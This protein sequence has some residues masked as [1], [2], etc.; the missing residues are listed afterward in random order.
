LPRGRRKNTD[1]RVGPHLCIYL[2]TYGYVIKSP[3]F[4]KFG[5]IRVEASAGTVTSKWGTAIDAG[6]QQVPDVL[7]RTQ[8]Q[9]GLSPLDLAILLNLTMHWWDKD[10]LPWPRPSVIAKRIGVSTR[11]IERRIAKMTDDGL[12]RRLPREKSDGPTIRRFD[13]SGLVRRLEGLADGYRIQ[14]RQKK[15]GRRQVREETHHA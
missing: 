2:G 8:S 5:E 7:I 3:I 4:R 6:F 10:N 15:G 11:T 12:I 14:Q 1:I 13:L 9:I